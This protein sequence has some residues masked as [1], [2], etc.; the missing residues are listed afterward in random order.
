MKFLPS[1]KKNFVIVETTSSSINKFITYKIPAKYKV[2]AE[3]WHVHESYIPVLLNFSSKSG[4]EVDTSALP[5]YNAGSGRGELFLTEDAPGFLVK[6]VWKALA[7]YYHPDSPTGNSELFI[8]FK[9]AYEKLK[10][11]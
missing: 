6:A 8:K 4:F 11:K 3:V 7:S 9:N 10:G 5:N 1:T 2:F